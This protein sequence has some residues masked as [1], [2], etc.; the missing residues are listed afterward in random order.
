MDDDVLDQMLATALAPI[1]RAADR[2]FVL[3]VEQ[4]IAEH[5][6]YCAERRRHMASFLAD[7]GGLLALVAGLAVLS[8]LPLFAA[9]IAPGWLGIASPLTLV[10]LLWLA[11]HSSLR[12]STSSP[13]SR[14]SKN[15]P[16]AASSGG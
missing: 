4:R 12:I 8:R 5:A 16:H 7:G 9:F 3:A 6:R 11:A 15:G 13:I 14:N 10:A 1:P 2:N